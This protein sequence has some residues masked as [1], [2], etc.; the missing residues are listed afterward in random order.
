MDKQKIAIIIDEKGWAFDNIANYLKKYIDRYSIDIIQGKLFEGNMLKLFLICQ[1]Y[2][3][4][5][6]AWRGYLSLIDRDVMHYYSENELLT[7]FREFENKYI[8]NKKISF[9]VCDELYLNGPDSWRTEEIMKYSKDYFVS[10]KR[11]E[12]IYN[13]FKYKPNRIIHD[14][15]DLER[16]K[17]RE[18]KKNKN[19]IIIG[20]VGNSNYKDSF[21]NEDLKGVHN[22]IKPA[23]EQL[24]TEEF[25]VKLKMADSQSNK[26][27]YEKMPDFYNSID[28][29][30]CASE[31]EG[32]PLTVLEAMATGKPIIST[33][34]GIISEA[35]G[36]I[37]KKYI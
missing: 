13:K 18:I 16:F 10:S 31:S 3:L 23:V 11:L 27:E 22:I 24:K 4:I 34:V 29:Y 35:F 37:Q 7:P 20:W 8:L 5:H 28:I 17:P 21:G 12:Q 26:I 14:G 6:F 25:N 19:E 30:V 32:T 9:S 36:R 2:D 1:D 15:V 33:D